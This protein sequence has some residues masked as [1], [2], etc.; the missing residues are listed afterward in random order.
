MEKVSLQE[1]GEKP[2]LSTTPTPIPS[3]Y[4]RRRRRG[5]HESLAS[6]A[7]QEESPHQ[8]MNLPTPLASRTVR[9]NCGVV[10]A[11]YFVVAA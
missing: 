3:H 9:N 4:G 5:H 6:S 7:S 8:E 10:E 11:R 1:E 2:E